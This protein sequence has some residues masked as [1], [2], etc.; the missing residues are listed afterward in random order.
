[1]FLF[2]REELI[3]RADNKK[4]SHFCLYITNPEANNMESKAQTITVQATVNAPV[5]KVW[6][7]WT[8]PQH[9][10]KWN[11]ASADWHT[12]RAE[13][14]LRVGGQFLSRMEA[15]DGSFGFDFGGV[16]DE[17]KPNGIIVYTI[18]DG[19]K[20]RI[21]FETL[22]NATTVTEIFEA[23]NTHPVEMQRG[24]WQAILDNF[25]NYAEGGNAG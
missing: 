23:E 21:S 17:V 18:G 19:R 11:N 8:T 1:L 25:K 9:I 12:P 20:V 7:L 6:K 16:Y 15:K 2:L 5:E 3:V 13:N 22:D 24:G 4:L 10:I 14:D